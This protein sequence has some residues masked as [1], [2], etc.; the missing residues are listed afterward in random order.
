MGLAGYD[1]SQYPL[2]EHYRR[3]RRYMNSMDW[4]EIS[5]A[6]AKKG[7]IAVD[8]SDAISLFPHLELDSEYQLICYMTSEYHGIFGRVTA[9]N[10]ADDWIPQCEIDKDFRPRSSGNKL[11]LPEC[12]LPP[13]EAIFNDGSAEGYFEAVLFSLFIHALPRACLLRDHWTYIMNTLPDNY[14]KKWE[15]QV[16]LADYS[17]RYSDQTITALNRILENGMSGSDGKD[18]IYLSR[19]EFCKNVNEY[20]FRTVIRT[21]R[22]IETK[23]I[24]E[25]KR[26]SEKRK[27]CVFTESCLLVAREKYSVLE[28]SP[29]S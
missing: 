9:V 14:E 16:T 15:Y 23:H 5:D 4:D 6:I 13:M 2:E 12:V 25:S 22:P 18:R 19:F 1:L 11:F 17:P 26:Y 20:L 29:D 3:C 8:V 21:K 24:T 27:C 28:K 7:T 10:K